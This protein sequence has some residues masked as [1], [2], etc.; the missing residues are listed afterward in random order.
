MGSESHVEPKMS[1]KTSMDK[2]CAF[3]ATTSYAGQPRNVQDRYAVA[4]KK[5]GNTI[6]HLPRIVSRVCSLPLLLLFL[7]VRR[8]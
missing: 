2:I 6:G 1:R 8:I 7:G 4:V 3:V 5:D